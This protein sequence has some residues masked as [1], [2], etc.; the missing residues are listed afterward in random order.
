MI[1]SD[2]QNYHPFILLDGDESCEYISQKRTLEE[3]FS[4]FNEEDMANIIT[5]EMDR[6]CAQTKGHL[7]SKSRTFLET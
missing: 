6:S 5:M 1:E 3:L 2:G 4:R 7:H